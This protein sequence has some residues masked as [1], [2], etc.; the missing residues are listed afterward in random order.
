MPFVTSGII[1]QQSLHLPIMWLMISSSAQ[2]QIAPKYDYCT[3]APPYGGAPHS[4]CLRPVYG[5]PWTYKPSAPV[6]L[7][8]FSMCLCGIS[9]L[10]LVSCTGIFSPSTHIKSV[11]LHFDTHF[12]RSCVTAQICFTYQNML[13]YFGHELI[14]AC[15]LTVSCSLEV[16]VQQGRL[17]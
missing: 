12:V 4:F 9:L 6:F 5:R 8:Y 13:L 2:G 15:Y 1:R 16:R 14:F 10:L 3:A 17:V 11:H 7:Q